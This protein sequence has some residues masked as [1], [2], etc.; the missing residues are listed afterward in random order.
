M[1]QIPDDADRLEAMLRASRVGDP[2]PERGPDCLDEAQLAALVD[3]ATDPARRERI[4]LHLAE[5]ASCRRAV[6][7]VAAALEDPEVAGA[8]AAAA[9]P[10]RRRLTRF[11]LPAT[12]AAAIVFLAVLGRQPGAPVNDPTHR[13]PEAAAP[14][15]PLA[16]A[17]LGAGPRPASLR[18]QAVPEA[19]LYR[20]TLYAM[21]GSVL[22]ARELRD[23]A[24]SL[25]D[26]VELAP[27]RSYRWL[28]EAR[29]GWNRWS[30]SDLFEFSLGPVSGR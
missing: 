3:G 15:Q 4:T 24:A 1:P 8:V 2:T 6:A 13:A 23:T 25:P 16:I 19:D 20:V 12:A 30:A 5:C 17:P 18:W 11:L 26:S 22:Y 28:V 21:D 10:V 14:G 9:P 27:G 29:T 7:S